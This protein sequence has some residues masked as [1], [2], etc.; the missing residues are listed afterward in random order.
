VWL[1]VS[2]AELPVEVGLHTQH[3]VVIHL[4]IVTAV[5]TGKHLS[6]IAVYDRARQTVL[7]HMRPGAHVRGAHANM[8]ADIE[9]GPT[10]RNGGSRFARSLARQ[11]S[12]SGV[13]GK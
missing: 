5:D 8:P 7:D 1:K 10:E 6:K 9:A 3:D 4:I 2:F 11:I 13:R 12:R